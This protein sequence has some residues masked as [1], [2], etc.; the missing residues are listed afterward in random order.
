MDL[1]TIRVK[2]KNKKPKRLGRGTGSTTGKTAGRG[3]KGAGQRKGKCLPYAG[4]RGGNLP[5]F[6]IIPKRGFN[7]HRKKEYQIVNLGQIQE[8]IKKAEEITPE[9][10]KEK[11]LIKDI[12]KPIKV[13]SKKEGDFTIKANFKADKFSVK[14]REIIEA[15]GGKVECLKR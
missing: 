10:L 7:P 1:S 9:L 6:R 4:F 15:A 3:H 2:T 14:A 11:N 5:Y 8:K 13:L 12:K